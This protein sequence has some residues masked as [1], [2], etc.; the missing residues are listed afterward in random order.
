MPK[1]ISL[2]SF[3]FVAVASRMPYRELAMLHL[4]DSLHEVEMVGA[5][6]CT[7][8]HASEDRVDDIT[9]VMKGE[10]VAQLGPR[11]GSPLP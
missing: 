10:L 1:I 4:G 9:N 2:A 8:M 7:V 11:E 6:L 5:D 3:A